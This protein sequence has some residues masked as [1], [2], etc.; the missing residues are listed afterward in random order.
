M[1]N[2]IVVNEKF[3]PLYESDARYFIVTGGRGSGKSYGATLIETTNTFKAGYNCLYT[4][5]TMTAA[6]LSI[7]PEFKEKIS[8]INCD[9][10]FDIQKKDIINTITN[11]RVLFRGIKTSSGNQTANLKSLQGISTWVLDEAEEMVS[12]E[13][14]DTIDLSIR[15]NLQQNRIVLIMNPA[16]KEHWVYKRFFESMGV[17]EGFNGKVGNVQYIHTTYLDNI[18]NLPQSFIDS[19]EQIRKTNPSKYKHKILGGWLDR[20]EGVVF[21]NWEYGEFNP[22]KL[23]T[24][25]GL[26]FGYSIDPDALVEVAIDKSKRII[27][28]KQ[29][30]YSKG[31]GSSQLAQIIKSRADRKLIIADSAEPRL[32]SDLRGKGINIKPV[33]KGKI[34][35]GVTLMQDF[36]LIVDKESQDIARELNNY[37]YLDKGSKLYIDDYNH[38]IDAARYNITFHLD[39]PH[40][41][42]YHVL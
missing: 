7:I 32:I 26:D 13:D 29:H 40:S 17:Q 19:V 25:F 23:Q 39:N 18:E 37:S 5:Y 16:T 22:N 41:G 15:S 27:Y 4:R 42:K 35:E 31:L 14:F 12:E 6:E 11:S 1:V 38:I 34:E 2:N 9:R 24:S 20:A 28:L 21:D 36:K 33:K 3:Q 8:L 30:I 10:Y